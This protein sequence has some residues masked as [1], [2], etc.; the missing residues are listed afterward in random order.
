MNRTDVRWKQRFQNFRKAYSLLR[1]ALEDR[2]VDSFND[3]E[4]EGVVQR[5]EY[6]FELAW[7]TTK[8]YLME[9]G[10]VLKEITPRNV[11]KE[12][13]AAGILADGQ[14]YMDMMLDRNL[15]SYC[16]DRQKFVEILKRIKKD[17][18][19]ALEQLYDFFVEK[20]LEWT[21]SY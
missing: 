1:G 4:Q 16:Y 6:T 21:G 17:Y 8:D 7:K 15:M 19:P 3:L 12:G 20:D 14:V 11:I 10:S 18:L 9:S 2:E 13:F 5:F